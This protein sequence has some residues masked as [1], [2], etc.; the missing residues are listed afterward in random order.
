[1]VTVAALALGVTFVHA[2]PGPTNLPPPVGD[3]PVNEIPPQLFKT[4]DACIS[5]HNGLVT[6]SGEDISIGTDWR[7]SMMANSARDPYWQAAVRR[8]VLDHPQAQEVIEDECAT[9]HMPM[10][11]FQARASGRTGEVFAHLPI[12]QA[13]TPAD[14]LAADGVSCTM[15]HQITE[16]KLGTRESFVGG[17]VVDTVTALGQRA[18]FGPYAVDTGR[19][20]VMH[21]AS[22]FRQVASDHIQQSELCAT[23]HTLYTKTLG[24][25]GEVVGALPE[26]VPY[27]EWRHSAYREERSCQSCHMPVVEDSTAITA[28]LGQPRAGVSRHVFRGGNFFMLR[29]LN[30]YRAQL[31]VEA[32]PQ[33]LDAAVRRTMQHLQSN[34]ARVSI[35]EAQVVGTRLQ[36]EVTMENLAG[37][38]LPTAYPSRRAWI[39]FTVHDRNGQLVFESGGLQPTGLIVGNDND[40]DPAQYEPHYTEI[41][42]SDRVQVYEVIMADPQGHVTTGLLTAVR[43]LK[44]N[45]LLP[46]GFDKATAEDDIAVEGRAA[47]DADFLGGS[48]RVRYA[49]DVAGA[50]GPFRVQAELWYQPIAYRWAQNLGPYDASETNR[51]VAFYDSM[52]DVSSV[53]L[54]TGVATAQ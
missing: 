17:F 10:A 4:G 11:R 35:E 1:M 22:G 27:L 45:R 51:F 43:F 37:H 24:P 6:P 44:D 33:E 18:V 28:V 15:C 49:V 47:K 13:T 2:L 20:T 54:A 8:E 5:C 19:R 52:S 41:T 46:R 12:G 50:Q 21:S 29:M 9:C 14:L 25:D 3:P 16:E 7:A 40:A 38:K 23:C 36:A 53:I 39:H 32:L 48:D 26:Q 31:G 34:T 30:R 42:R